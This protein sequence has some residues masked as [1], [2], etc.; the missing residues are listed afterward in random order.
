MPLNMMDRL[1][2]PYSNSKSAR[3]SKLSNGS[4]SGASFGSP[5]GA[6]MEPVFALTPVPVVALAVE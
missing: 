1:A 4:D 6:P 2:M 5:V 3:F